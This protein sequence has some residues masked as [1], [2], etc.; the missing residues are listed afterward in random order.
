MVKSMREAK[1]H[2]T[3]ASPNTAYEDAM[4]GFVRAALD[5]STARTRFWMRFCPFQERVARLGR[6][7]QP[8]ADRAEADAARA[9]P[10][11]I[12]ARSCGT[13]AW[14]IPDNRRPVDYALRARLLRR[15]MAALERDRRD[16]MLHMLENWRDGRC[17]LAVTAALLAHAARIAEA[18]RRRRLSAARG[19]RLQGRPDLRLCAGLTRSALVVVASRFPVRFGTEPDW[20]GT[21]VGFRGPRTVRRGGVTC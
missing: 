10:T 16:G 2:S 20:D 1:V 4:L 14:S 7:Q 12:R 11:S 9:C 15:D 21:E 5:M 13:S 19:H 6:P 18:V 17:K 3:W 8:G